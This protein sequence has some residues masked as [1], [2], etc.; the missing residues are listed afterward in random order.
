MILKLSVQL[1][2][3]QQR[4]LSGF[5]LQFLE[6]RLRSESEREHY[7]P[8]LAV[9]VGVVQAWG[10]VGRWEVAGKAVGIAHH[11][12]LVPSEKSKLSYA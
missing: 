8:R 5:S 3:Y 9:G 12:D 1:L 4:F 2:Y 7:L 10:P 11:P 6:T